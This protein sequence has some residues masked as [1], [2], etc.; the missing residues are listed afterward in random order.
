MIKITQRST[1]IIWQIDNKYSLP[2]VSGQVYWNGSTKE[3]EISYNGGYVRIDPN[4][5]LRSDP[6]LSEVID[7]AEKKMEEDKKI[8]ELCKQF[9]ALKNAKEKYEIILKL[10]GNGTD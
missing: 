7:W 8:D 4:I 2:S 5:E 10:V 9:P 1:P 3:F 6:K